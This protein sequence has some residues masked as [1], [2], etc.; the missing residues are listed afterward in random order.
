MPAK[1]KMRSCG[2]AHPVGIVAAHLNHFSEQS[3]TPC[4]ERYQWDTAAQGE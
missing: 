2:A 3:T 1:Q 4:Q